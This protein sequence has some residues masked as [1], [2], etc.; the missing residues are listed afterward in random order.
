MTGN[1]TER[2]RR[3]LGTVAPSGRL[4]ELVE[5]APES[6]GP[7]GASDLERPL[8]EK[9][10]MGQPLAPREE[11][12]L[13]A[14]IIP[15]KRPAIDI[16]DGTYTAAHAD[17]LHLNEPAT[18]ARLEAA[19]PSIGR[20]EVPGHP[21]APYGG[22][23]FVVGDGLLMTNRHVAEMFS[24]GL[25]TRNLFFIPG[26]SSA[27]DFHRER[28]DTAHEPITATRLVMI[29]PFWDMALF[30]IDGLPAGHKPLTLDITDPEEF[31][32]R[33]I[34]V[35]GYPAFDV[36]NPHDVQQ[37]VFGGTYGI[38]R[39]QPGKMR[40]RAKVTSYDR[41]VSAPTHDSSTLGGNSGSCVIDIA[42]GRIVALHFGGRYLEAN[43]AVASG[44]LAL[45]GRVIDAGVRFSSVPEPGPAPW[46][47]VW[48]EIG[49]PE[50]GTQE[51]EQLAGTAVQATGTDTDE[52][53]I[54]LEITVRLGHGQTRVSIA[55]RTGETTA[56]DPD[57]RNRRGFDP[58][59]LGPKIRMPLPRA[60]ER[61]VRAL[62]G[63]ALLH[64]H[65]FSL[66]MHRDRRLAAMAAANIDLAANS[67][68][69][70]L[71]FGTAQSWMRDPRL[72][73][74][75]QLPE[76][77]FRSA[78]PPF[79]PGQLVKS[80]DVAWGAA[81]D[82]T[83]D[84]VADCY[85]VTNAAPK[86]LSARRAQDGWDNVE[87][88]VAAQNDGT[89]LS[90]FS[91]PVLAPDDPEIGLIEAGHLQLPRRYWKLVVA[92]KGASLRAY[93]VILRQDLLGVSD[94][95]DLPETSVSFLQ[96]VAAIEALSGFDFDAT[97]H[98]A[99]MFG[100]DEA[101][102]LAAAAGIGASDPT[103]PASP[104][105]GDHAASD[106]LADIA[107]ILDLWREEQSGGNAGDP[108]RFVLELNTPVPDAELQTQLA[109][110]LGLDLSVRPLF[111]GDDEGDG[112]LDRF[113]LVEIP[114]IGDADRADLFDVARALRALTDA[115]AV[116]P[117]L[118]TRYYDSDPLVPPDGTAE[119]GNIAFW[120]W[121]GDDQAPA[122]ADWAIK[123]LKMEEAWARSDAAGRPSRGAGS[124]I[125]QPDTGVVRN[126]P[127]IPST[128]ADDPR[129]AN[130]V[131]P[132]T[133]PVDPMRGSGNLG[134]GTATGSVAASPA[135]HRV[136]GAAPKAELVPL[137]ALRS[138]VRFEQSRVAAAVNHARR[139]GAHVITMSLGGVP[140]SALRA[141]IR[142]AVAQNIIVL[143]AAGN[144]VG[145]VVWPA[146]Y[147]E[148]I[149][150]GGVNA[151]D[152]P[153]QGSSK[154]RSVDVSA[155]AE[156]VLR[157]DARDP[158]DPAKTS[159]GQ[160]TSFATALLA[161]VAAC[162][163][164]HHGRDA[165]IAGLSHGETLQTR[166]RRLLRDT[167]RVPPGFDTDRYGAGIVDADA[168]IAADPSVAGLQ[169]SVMADIRSVE[170]E[171]L[172]IFHEAGAAARAEAAA[173]AVGDPQSVLELACVAFDM[174][175]YR[176]MRHRSLEAQPPAA[177]SRGLTALM[178]QNAATGLMREAL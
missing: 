68:G 15:D 79:D 129:A 109:D 37:S 140:S 14:I 178:G 146:R 96:S 164:S 12:A 36:R 69:P 111:D 11:F 108:A 136:T 24:L 39:L 59:F 159:G 13:E 123:R 16:V 174:A 57:Y 145:S 83:K 118:G 20:V 148:V 149:A 22:T 61:L 101:A 166:F 176:N 34:A 161:G 121:A 64:Y 80:R 78:N 106:A 144:C 125:F 173:Q 132:G 66:F 9:L 21:T 44:D 153:W 151:K 35:V 170:R 99:C 112:D 154:G 77:L 103:R 82:E 98:K 138:V 7:T 155:P 102:A 152:R 38:K 70:G 90:V 120:C 53:T 87:R 84:A 33:D 29:H 150:V 63:E 163:L 162:W 175:R 73:P 71:A 100:T 104:A 8:L 131:E 72:D 18:L 1:R 76:S 115:V 139:N 2:A 43:Y 74:A 58:L 6:A 19:F 142:K 85:H 116:E 27:V 134:H 128:L 126:H 10:A 75:A 55:G 81:R 165:L 62:D 42:T 94:Q 127:D 46:D 157:A 30:E 54:P 48:R 147:G 156:F 86:P 168:F 56:P 137:R 67:K 88:H 114:G 4:E 60:P 3:Y 130:F 45:D 17:W 172:E 5:A 41:L 49:V 113:R 135:S 143:A 105:S 89:K 122:D 28:G 158:A 31:V 169:E 93:G 110:A 97:L 65:H 177:L 133:P 32:G 119:S 23:A 117:D 40:G 52:L 171:V 91:G 50:P 167:A 51:P 25:G 107:E 141:A 95:F 124:V 92:R 160:G 47:A 26:R